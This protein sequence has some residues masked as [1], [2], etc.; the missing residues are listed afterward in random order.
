MKPINDN[1]SYQLDIVLNGLLCLKTCLHIVLFCDF[2]LLF[3]LI[4]E[5]SVFY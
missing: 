2:H 1:Y 3:N 4:P 5:S